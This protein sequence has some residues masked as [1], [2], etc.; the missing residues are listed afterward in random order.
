MQAEP[1]QR[2]QDEA[3][4]KPTRY[5]KFKLINTGTEIIK[6]NPCKNGDENVCKNIPTDMYPGLF[7]LLGC[8]LV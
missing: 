2:I 4:V 3:N 8:Y 5:T 6:T 1:T 7:Q